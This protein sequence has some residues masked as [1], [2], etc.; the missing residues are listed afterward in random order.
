[1]LNYHFKNVKSFQLPRYQPI[2][3]NLGC[4]ISRSTSLPRSPLVRPCNYY[5]KV[6]PVPAL[7]FKLAVSSGHSTS[8]ALV[9]PAI[10]HRISSGKSFRRIVRKPVSLIK[11][12]PLESATSSLTRSC[13]VTHIP[14]STAL[15]LSSPTVI[16]STSQPS[17][18][19]R[20]LKIPPIPQQLTDS[21]EA[22]HVGFHTYPS[23]CSLGSGE[24]ESTALIHRA[25]VPLLPSSSLDFGPSCTDV[26]CLQ[27]E[28]NAL[29]VAAK[30]AAVA[31]TTSAIEN[32][33]TA[34]I[35]QGIFTSAKF[36]SPTSL[37]TPTTSN[38]PMTSYSIDGLSMSP[39]ENT[40]ISSS[41]TTC[42]SLTCSSSA[43]PGP[44]SASNIL[45]SPTTSN[46]SGAGPLQKLPLFDHALSTSRHLSSTLPLSTSTTISIA[47]SSPAN[48]CYLPAPI[49]S[50]S[51]LLS[52]S[53]VQ[54][55]PNHLPILAP[56]LHATTPTTLML[57][58]LPSG[59]SQSQ[60]LT[61]KTS[62]ADVISELA[63]SL[64]ENGSSVTGL[65][66]F[67]SV[68]P[69]MASFARLHLPCSGFGLTAIPIP[70][71][72][73]ESITY[74]PAFANNTVYSSSKG[75]NDEKITSSSPPLTTGLSFSHY[76]IA[77]GL[78]NA[79][80]AAAAAAAASSN[81]QV[82]IPN[83]TSIVSGGF[84]RIRPLGSIGVYQGG[85]QSSNSQVGSSLNYPTLSQN[86]PSPEDI[87]LLSLGQFPSY[88]HLTSTSATSA[89][90]LQINTPVGQL[91]PTFGYHKLVDLPTLG[92]PG[93]K[94]PVLSS[95][96]SP[97]MLSAMPSISRQVSE[98]LT[99]VASET[100]ISRTSE[101]PALAAVAV[102]T[103]KHPLQL[104]LP[105]QVPATGLFTHSQTIM[106]R[107]TKLP[108]QGSAS[109]GLNL[110]PVSSVSLSPSSRFTPT[111]SSSI[112]PIAE[113]GESASL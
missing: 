85:F 94:V 9:R 27:A 51:S 84:T 96:T 60:I 56:F 106:E 105:C 2:K 101:L 15:E 97:S 33:D 64:P 68:D 19:S 7:S 38:F 57:A 81:N 59:V 25:L 3:A 44:S 18:G 103:P 100:T 112:T 71:V 23:L 5:S 6:A 70:D 83:V 111:T 72:K 79:A 58:H 1:M 30:A 62:S 53:N 8:R 13:L 86:Q 99:M 109:T 55:S 50:R 28:S 39:G 61:A 11:N 65:G 82:Y 42:S 104:H 90:V 45:A 26:C 91:A 78:A 107:P 14:A 75:N 21:S 113:V 24:T 95:S 32:L 108:L 76:A 63:V 92:S 110:L 66:K 16:F 17:I 52:G 54:L 31:E 69:V 73:N 67:S 29:L 80:A 41:I 74:L 49:S 34:S 37:I 93:L 40:G 4:P 87:S 35:N 98:P 88:P 47:P 10:T 89:P 36:N 12:S 20:L 48:A 22:C 43:P 46:Q 102:A 77:V